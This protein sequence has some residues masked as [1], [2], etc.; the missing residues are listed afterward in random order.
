[1][2]LM[3]YMWDMNINRYK[4]RQVKKTL[5]TLLNKWNKCDLCY[6]PFLTLVTLHFL[7]S[8]FFLIILPWYDTAEFVSALPTWCSD[9][10]VVLGQCI[11]GVFPEI[12]W[13]PDGFVCSPYLVSVICLAPL[14]RKLPVV[15]VYLEDLILLEGD[16]GWDLEWDVWDE[17]SA[18]FQKLCHVSALACVCLF[19]LASSAS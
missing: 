8:A 15:G 18:Y 14:S 1:M 6:M 3:C 12:P 7:S 11:P 19:M 2:L 10:E 17:H 5:F 16:F 13:K 4:Q 9:S